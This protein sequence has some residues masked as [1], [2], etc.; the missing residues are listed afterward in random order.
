LGLEIPRDFSL[1]NFNDEFPVEH[2]APPLTVVAPESYEMGRL[3]AEML[4]RRMAAPEDAIP[5]ITRV[6][7][8]LILRAST[9]A[10]M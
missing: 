4:L 6:P 8:K 3:G 1:I 2:L 5:A 9:A 7:A 10:N